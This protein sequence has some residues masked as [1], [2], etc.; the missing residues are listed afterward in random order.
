MT[1]SGQGTTKKGVHADDHAIIYTS[2]PT[3]LRGEMPLSKQPIKVKPDTIEHKLDPASRLNYAKVYTIE[4]N[5]KVWCIG[6]IHRD[7]EWKLI[8]AYNN[9]H[10]PIK[11]RFNESLHGPGQF[12][13]PGISARSP[14]TDH[15]ADQDSL[16]LSQHAR[17]PGGLPPDPY[18]SNLL[19]QS[20]MYEPQTPRRSYVDAQQSSTP[21]QETW[22]R[23]ERPLQSSFYPHVATS[24]I[25]TIQFSPYSNFGRTQGG[26]SYYSGG[27]VEYPS[28]RQFSS[29][30]YP[31]PSAGP[32]NLQ[33]AR[34]I[35]NPDRY[36]DF[37]PNQELYD[38]N[39][40]YDP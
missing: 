15:F 13:Y 34:A 3:L 5:V 9:D 40:L 21:A 6:R 38:D 2:R 24:S 4:H 8:S 11:Q 37:Y 25:N 12:S 32:S 30:P 39:S 14:Q 1:Y 36:R 31:Q 35:N 33:G 10:P 16:S 26:S 27:N 28:A 17:S 20:S 23:P 19:A 7:D 29:G 22:Q 18:A